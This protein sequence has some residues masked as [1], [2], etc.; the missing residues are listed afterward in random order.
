MM[1]KTENVTRRR[2]GA[3]RKPKTE[4]ELFAQVNEWNNQY[5]VGM[6][7]TVRLDDGSAKDTATTST[8]QVLG[9]HS[10]VIWLEGISGCYA[11]NRV[12]AVEDVAGNHGAHGVTRPTSEVK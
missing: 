8:A 1:M 12:T 4:A 10:A 7:V 9:G 5:P 2:G 3:E 11:I 6:K